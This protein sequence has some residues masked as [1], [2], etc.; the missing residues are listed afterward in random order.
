MK[1]PD[2]SFCPITPIPKQ[3]GPYT[4]LKKIASGGM[5]DVFLAY[6]PFCK[7]EL[8]LKQIRSDKMD[9]PGLKDRF[10]KEVKIAAQLSHPSIIP[11]YQIHQ[12]ETEVY[13]TMPLVAGETLKEIIKTTRQEE[14][15]GQ[16]THPIGSSI[17]ALMR[18]FLSICQ[19]VAYSHAKGV[20]HRDLKPENIIIGPYGEVL[21]LDWGLADF[22][23]S[24]EEDNPI[25]EKD[26]PEDSKLT[27][28]GKI[29]GTLSYLP[30]ERIFGK[31]A[32]YA[33]DIYALG[34]ILYQLL[35]L[36][37][38]F[39][40]KTVKEYK[41]QCKQETLI[42]PSER[43]PHR[44]I[45]PQLSKIAKKC[46][47]SRPEKRYG[48]VEEI[49]LDLNNYIEGHAQWIPKAGIH[50]DHKSD[51]KF[52]ENVLIAKHIALTQ[53]SDVMEWV[54]LMIAEEAFPGAIKLETHVRVKEGGTGLGFLLNLKLEEKGKDFFQEGFFIWIGSEKSPGSH[55][56]RSNVELM[57]NPDLYL[58][59]QL[60]HCICIEKSDH[61]IRLYVDNF[62]A[63]DYLSHTPF[64][65]PYFGLVFKDAD[66]EVGTILVSTS[67][68]DILINCLA[69]PDA[70]LTLHHFKEA[71]A[72]YRQIASSFAGRPE[73][74]E[75]LFRAGI[76]LLEEA[77]ASK[78]KK[79]KLLEEALEEFNKLRE[80]GSPLEYLGKSLVYK[81]TNELEE[82]VK[83]L[84]LSLRKF[85]K[86]PLIYLVKEQVLFRL[87]E[88]SYKNKTAAYEFALLTL[89]LIPEAFTKQDNQNLL[90][91]LYKNCE[92]PEFLKESAEDTPLYLTIK[93]SFWLKKTSLLIE[94]YFLCQEEKHKESILY[95]LAYLG[96]EKADPCLDE[97]SLFYEDP[98]SAICNI[99]YQKKLF[100][101]FFDQFYLSSKEV[102][103]LLLEKIETLCE[104]DLPFEE[105]IF[106]Q[107]YQ[108]A[109][110]LYLQNTQKAIQVLESLPPSSYDKDSSFLYFL[111][112][113]A[114]IAEQGLSAA[115]DLLSRHSE[116]ILPPAD[117]LID[118]FLRESPHWKKAWL[119]K[120]LFWEKVQLYT[121]LTFFYQVSGQKQEH[122]KALRK[123]KELSSRT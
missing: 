112:S 1:T 75:A 17:P 58:K 39:H 37:A 93:L 45:P 85:D 102:Q 49:L 113:C 7:R 42:D 88:A 101:F 22:I 120:A 64:Q 123:L 11:I 90:Q 31:K 103:K 48:R 117:Y 40:R 33:S 105:R 8:A 91:H 35:S 83:C 62:L 41:R 38:P 96:H 116:S 98:L 30:P 54:S 28:P 59:N 108:I 80:E 79:K 63:F 110:N 26:V 107:K 23:D 109:F 52:Q 65:G 68:P 43:A 87:H 118:Y 86:H 76:T 32:S 2:P 99:P 19:A 12:T 13:Y 10:L 119:Q 70:L 57:S 95:A 121:Q 9:L 100:R 82:E 27:R 81:A 106:L 74:K 6:D 114:V 53:K 14:K 66:L 36:R 44:D 15:N 18:I 5:G 104:K 77:L 71:L 97:I 115:K 60:S 25:E 84:E 50:I 21:I 67:S 55:L 3:I 51:W 20:L 4:I 46:L 61:H 89:R 111:K 47:A 24:S 34:V 16:S 78:S 72:Q 92:T 56:F 69:V 122:D 73:G 29:A 94:L